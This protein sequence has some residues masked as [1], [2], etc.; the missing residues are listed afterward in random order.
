H[1]VDHPGRGLLPKILDEVKLLLQQQHSNMPSPHTG[2]A[3]RSASGELPHHSA[4][5]AVKRS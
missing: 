2:H 4:T 5:V 1:H 3:A